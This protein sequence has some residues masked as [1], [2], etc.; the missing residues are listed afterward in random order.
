MRLQ[1]VKTQSA[2]IKDFRQI[3]LQENNFQFVY[4]KCHYYGWA[5]VYVFIANE[6]RIGYGAVWG[7]DKR[8]ERDTIF[9]FYIL[10]P[11]RK[12]VS[13]IFH[14]FIST[15][16]TKKIECQSNDLLLTGMLY[17]FAKNIY[18]EAILFEDHVQ[19]SF[20]LPG[21][22]FGRNQKEQN[23]ETDAGGYYLVQH[24][25]VVANGGFM[26]NYNFPYADIY[27]DVKENC[28]QRGLGSLLV[29]E[30][31]KEIYRMGRVP[32]ARCNI[33]NNA[34]KATLIKAGMIPCG[35]IL[36]GDIKNGGAI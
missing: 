21:V 5:D 34:S 32:A 27:M 9:E 35:F 22:Y 13:A 17:E 28:R 18:A 8:E 31:K 4:D 3:F 19:T 36:R 11:Y 1:I 16:G 14:D 24:S 30:L 12:Y 33:S 7:T 23:N 25:E 2:D 26:L 29:Q 10:P 20:Q 15:S 6:A